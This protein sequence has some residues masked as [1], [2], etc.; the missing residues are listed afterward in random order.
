ML[1]HYSQQ[2]HSFIRT[3]GISHVGSRS[4]V[5][6]DATHS[7]N[8]ESRSLGTANHSSPSPMAL[9]PPLAPGLMLLPILHPAQSALGSVVQS[10][11]DAVCSE[12][13]QSIP[14]HLTVQDLVILSLSACVCHKYFGATMEAGPSLRNR[15]P[16]QAESRCPRL[17]QE[18]HCFQKW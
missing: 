10:R 7:A 17:A 9:I 11:A 12:G 13:L 1:R 3:L 6:D 4:K 5:H 14:L 18:L 8:N 16:R 2:V 15:C